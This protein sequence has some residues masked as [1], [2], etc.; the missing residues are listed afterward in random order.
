MIDHGTLLHRLIIAAEAVQNLRCPGDAEVMQNLLSDVSR[1]A[2]RP[3]PDGRAIHTYTEML[4]VAVNEAA[5]HMRRHGAEHGAA[6]FRIVGVIL[7]DVRRDFGMAIE[8]RR[9]PTP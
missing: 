8:A 1:E 6:Y 4:A 9:R 3:A 7:P 5:R 2:Q